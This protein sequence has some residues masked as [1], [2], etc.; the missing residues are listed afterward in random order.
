MSFN[1]RGGHT[2]MRIWANTH[3]LL[4]ALAAMEGKNM[5]T[6]LDELLRRE[7]DKKGLVLNDPGPATVTVGPPRDN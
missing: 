7:A 4:R 3:A 1:A 6:Y 5:M 2:M